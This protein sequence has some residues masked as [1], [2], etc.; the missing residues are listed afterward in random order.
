M[1]EI[2]LD[3]INCK[4]KGAISEDVFKRLDKAMSY[5]HPG[6]GFMSGARGGFGSGGKYGGWDGKVRLL[7]KSG[8]FPIGLLKI[9]KEIMKEE[10]LAYSV[11][12]RRPNISYGKKIP[13]KS[14]AFEPRSYQTAAIKKAVKEGSGIIKMA[15]GS[16]KSFVI[17]SL[18]ASYN[19]PT[20]VYVI[21]IELLY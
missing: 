13:Q 8:K 4:I 12:D 19:I 9:A 21:G 15:T 17:A 16:G 6:Y 10:G 1:V 11:V 3:N 5:D 2:Y 7:Q 18:V 14:S 20:I